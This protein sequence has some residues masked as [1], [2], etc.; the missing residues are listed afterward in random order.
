MVACT[1]IRVVY[2][3]N[4]RRAQNWGAMER[5]ASLTQH[6][7]CFPGGSPGAEE[8]NEMKR[9][10]PLFLKIEAYLTKMNGYCINMTK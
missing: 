7:F 10:K 1:Y 5:I 8:R 4:I 2:S 9:I 3:F 6:Q